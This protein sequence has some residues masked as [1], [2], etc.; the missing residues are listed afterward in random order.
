MILGAVLAGGQ[1]SRFGSDKAMALLEGRALIDHVI[2]A[3]SSKVDG[4]I[5]CGRT[6][7][8]LT[9]VPDRPR[10]ELGPL[11]GINAAL[12]YAADN[13]YVKVLTAPCDTPRISQDLLA[14][15]LAAPAPVYLSS[16]PVLGCWPSVLA[17]Q[18]DAHLDQA[19]DLSIRRW[20]RAIGATALDHAAPLNINAPEDWD[21]L[22]GSG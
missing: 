11:G 7:P 3:L 9:G 6:Y 12:R 1:S 15:L 4:T 8:S 20:S 19:T 14:A 2:L 13:G 10:P 17:D 22:D 21:L 18:L 16:L 5:V